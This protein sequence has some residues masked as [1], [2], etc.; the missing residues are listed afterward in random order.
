MSSPSNK[1]EEDLNED[2]MS[3]FLLEEDFKAKKEK[4]SGRF[5]KVFYLMAAI[6]VIATV[7]LLI[8][9][10]IPKNTLKNPVKRN[11][12][13]MIGDGFGP[14]AATM[15]R[16]A[17]ETKSGGVLKRLNLDD[18]L[19]GTVKT[20]SNSSW[21][22]DSAAGA[23]AYATGVHTYNEG[24]SI[25][26]SKKPV[27]TLFEAA[28]TKN[29]KT[30]VVVTTRISDATPACFFSHSVS[31]K[32]EYFIIEQILE[33]DMDIILGGGM[34][35]WNGTYDLAPA[36][37]YTCVQTK[38]DMLKVESGKILG[39]FAPENL[40]FEIDRKTFAKDTPTLKEMT[41]KALELINKDNEHGFILMVEGSQ[42][43][44][45]GHAN[46]AAAQIQETLMFDE[47]FQAVLDFALSDK[48][49][50]IIVTADHETGG[51]TLGMQPDPLVYPEQYEWQPS[52]LLNMT[53]ST[54]VLA[55]MI[56]NAS[57][58]TPTANLTQ[59]TIDLVK[60]YSKVDLT[61]ADIA[62]IAPFIPPSNSSWSLGQVLGKIVSSK[63][64][65]G[66][67][68]AGHTGVDVNLYFYS[69]SSDVSPLNGN[70][71]NI[72]LS[73]YVADILSLDLEAETEKLKNFIPSPSK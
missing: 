2:G 3:H 45:A 25:D 6:V 7:V 47:T 70:V 46:D 41:L 5:K 73:T 35:F 40:P 30:G 13:F 15:A 20:F 1:P 66:W 56:V 71:E 72:H 58:L 23:T 22:T 16:V 39:L 36:Q 44:I 32:D 27:G 29:M 67:T 12:I 63:A 43:D 50:V 49:T 21:V 26:P 11:V 61:L 17:Q 37:G 14:A 52:V 34:K 48:D 65:V 64:I 60:Q 42:I 53:A 57:I 28:K 33:K 10:L 51:L 24:V 62:Y 18:Y 4:I 55:Q 68:T 69:D 31:R 59:L 8:V 38:E 19:V 54:T 9:F